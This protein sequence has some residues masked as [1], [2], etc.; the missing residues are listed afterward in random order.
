MPYKP[1]IKGNET[2]P[3][4][5]QIARLRAAD[6]CGGTD[7]SSQPGKTLRYTVWSDCAKGTRVGFAVYSAGGHSF[8]PP[9]STQPAAATVIWAFFN[10]QSLSA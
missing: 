2:P 9:S 3:A 8:P 4:T 10:H 6:G 1:G 7:V 5:V